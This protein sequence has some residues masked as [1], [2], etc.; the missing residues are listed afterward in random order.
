MNRIRTDVT[1]LTTTGLLTAAQLGPS[2]AASA[3]PTAQ[4]SGCPLAVAHP[5]RF[6]VDTHGRGPHPIRMRTPSVCGG[7][8]HFGIKNKRTTKSFKKVAFTVTNVEDV[9][10]G[11]ATANGGK[12]GHQTSKAVS[13]HTT[14]PKEK[15]SLG[16]TVRTRLLDTRTY[17]ARFTLS[18]NGWNCAADQGTWGS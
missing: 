6:S 16:V 2:Q 13:V 11:S 14:T 1:V 18:G 7:G 15:A 10:F 12:I 17:K 8:R 4:S 3:Q 5:S 9:G